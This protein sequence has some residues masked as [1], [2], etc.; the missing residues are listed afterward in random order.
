MKN[1]GQFSKHIS[2]TLLGQFSL[3]LACRVVHMEGIKHVNLIEISP[4]VIEIRR[5][6]NSELAVLLMTHLCAA[7]LSWLLTYNR[8]S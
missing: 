4:V 3:N 2:H 7:R 5:V 6:E 1:I 8:V